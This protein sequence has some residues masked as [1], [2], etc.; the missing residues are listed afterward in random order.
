MYGRLVTAGALSISVAASSLGRIMEAS[1]VVKIIPQPPAILTYPSHQLAA[2]TEQQYSV[3]LACRNCRATTF[4]AHTRPP[5][6]RLSASTLS[7]SIEPCQL[8]PVLNSGA[9]NHGLMHGL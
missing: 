1:L 3:I 8:I 7:H 9:S 2:S 6:E 4:K 5:D